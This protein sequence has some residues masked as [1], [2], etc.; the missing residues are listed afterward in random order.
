MCA[1]ALGLLVGPQ[2][3][4]RPARADLRDVASRVVDEW[5]R[6][7]GKVTRA[8]TR[9]V[10]EDETASFAVPP[11]PDGQ[12]TT[13]AM[14]GA[15]GLSFH[16]KISGTDDDPLGAD[17][18]ARAAS[19]A[20]VA[21]IGRCEG[22]PMR[23]LIVTSD[24]GRGAIEIVVAHSRSPVPPLRTV[25]PERTGGV[26]P[27]SAEP[28]VLPPLAPPSHRADVA[29]ARARR[30]GAAIAARE[31]WPAGID[32]NGDGHLELDA[33][34]HR[35]ELFANDPRSGTASR[36]FRLDIDA[37]LRDEED[38]TMLGRDR[39]E[40]PDAH[41]E[42]CLGKDTLGAVVFSGA[43]PSSSVV[44]T[45]V[46]WPIP[47]TLPW[48]WGPETRGKM[49][50][51][52]LARHIAT[53]P[54]PPVA[55]AQGSSGVTLVPVEIEPGGCYVAVAAVTQGHARGVGLRALVGA[56]QSSDERGINDEAGAVAFCARE[57]S[58]AKLEVEARGTALSW[59]LALF[60][61]DGG[62]WG[63]S[64]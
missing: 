56:R 1:L 38:D 29:E 42:A 21:Q 8:P 36:R 64:R 55:L 14:V 30:D 26:T 39:T 62:I 15:R 11:A 44:M 46:S 13:V 47:R 40:A 7:G 54:G 51:A 61:I 60:R 52:M 58:R 35:I 25:L 57:Q 37:E 17:E 32:G 63:A 6:A 34:C 53:P 31:A 20:G 48:A 5:Q 24:A 59:G 28:G 18:G 4:A 12:C 16:V 43:P 19:V 22:P 41:I 9:F 45:H 10:Y 33:G 49:A 50:G 23:R 3:V 27:P 2:L